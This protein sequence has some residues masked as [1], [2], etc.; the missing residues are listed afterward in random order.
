MR[1][2]VK[3]LDVDLIRNFGGSNIEMEETKARDYEKKK[4]VKIIRRI[5]DKKVETPPKDK[6]IWSPPESKMFNNIEAY[7]NI[8]DSLFPDRIQG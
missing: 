5:E 3:V 7:P 6:K 2:R 4:K 8:K 1:V